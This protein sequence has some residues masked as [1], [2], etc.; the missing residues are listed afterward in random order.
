E[1]T[2]PDASFVFAD[3]LLAFDH[4]QGH[5]YLLCLVDRDTA[6]AGERWLSET[7]G[8]LEALPPLDPI[9]LSS[10]D[11]AEAPV[12]FRLSRSHERYVADIER[13]KEFLLEGETYEVCLTNKVWADVDLDPL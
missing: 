9:D 7:A 8:A 11:V 4:E 6:E 5:T 13:C 12:A 1:S 2:L 10:V 3:R